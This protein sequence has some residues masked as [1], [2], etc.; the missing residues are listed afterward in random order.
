MRKVEEKGN[1]GSA[2]SLNYSVADALTYSVADALTLIAGL[3][4]G[5]AVNISAR[6]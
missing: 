1:D 5:S 3:H 6:K 4:L 2:D